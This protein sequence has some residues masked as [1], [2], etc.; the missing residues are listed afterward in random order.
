M[1]FLLV[2]LRFLLLIF[3]TLS[4][5]CDWFNYSVPKTRKFCVHEGIKDQSKLV[6]GTNKYFKNF[7]KNFNKNFQ[8]STKKTLK[9]VLV[10]E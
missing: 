6:L 1:F 3:L 4:Q 9:K 2:L 10:E 8:N 5:D 7:I